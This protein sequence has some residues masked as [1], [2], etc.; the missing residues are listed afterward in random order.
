MFKLTELEIQKIN[1]HF[2][3]EFFRKL[4]GD[5]DKYSSIWSLEVVELVNHFSGCCVFYC[6]SKNYGDVVLKILKPSKENITE[7]RTLKE[8]DGNKFCKVLEDDINNGVI[9]LER[10]FPGYCLKDEE[11]LE[12]RLQVFTNIYNNLYIETQN[13]HEY[14]TYSYWVS[15]ITEFMRNKKEYAE[16]YSYMKAAQDIYIHLSKTYNEEK[17]LHG[18]LH[19]YNILKSN[20]GYRV[21]DPK[22]VVGDPVFDIARFMLNEYEKDKNIEENFNKVC[23]VIDFFEKELNVDKI[24]LKQVYYIDAVMTNCWFVEDNIETNLDVIEIARRLLDK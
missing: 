3:N 24:V 2:G 7:Y 20:K 12:K 19:Q 1:N 14:P 13:K 4:T 21:I 6:K 8:Y 16:L 10:I 11:L 18:D 9:L 17:L 22:G 15:R 5:L 23:K